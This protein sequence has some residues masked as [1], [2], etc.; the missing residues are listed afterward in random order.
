MGEPMSADLLFV[1]N[2]DQEVL[3][4][5][6]V[7]STTDFHR[8][9]CPAVVLGN[10]LVCQLYLIG[11]DGSYRPESGA[12]DHEPEMQIFDPADPENVLIELSPEDFTVIDDGWQFTLPLTTEE[13]ADYI[14][15]K[16]AKDAG[17]EIGFTKPDGKFKSLYRDSIPLLA[18]VFDAEPGS[19]DNPTQYLTALQSWRQHVRN[20]PSVLALT[21]GAGALD[22]VTTLDGAV[23]AGD[24]LLIYLPATEDVLLYVARAGEVPEAGTAWY[25]QS[26]DQPADLY[27][28]LLQHLGRDNRQ[29]IWCDD[30]ERF[31]AI[32]GVGSG[33]SITLALGEPFEI[34]LS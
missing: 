27:Y 8:A 5:R 2:L 22:G 7:R 18:E 34:P 10:T 28:E 1:L 13:L 15:N 31:R 33:D 17:L 26:L 23:Q 4:L 6:R 24:K 32:L 12:G 20:M 25:V 19:P 21:G 14:G 30:E 3:S 16:V 29:V 11:G 9:A